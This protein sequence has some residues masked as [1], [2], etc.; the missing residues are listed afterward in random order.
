MRRNTLEENE[1]HL[2]QMN[3]T[4]ALELDLYNEIYIEPLL[5]ILSPYLR[6]FSEDISN[7]EI[8]N[9]FID[10]NI[11]KEELNKIDM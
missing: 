11:I 2:D 8:D 5:K 10:L 9:N 1:E 7:F 3:K 4:L 6:Y